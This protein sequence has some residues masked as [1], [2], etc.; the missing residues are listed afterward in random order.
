MV[1]VN[2]ENDFKQN[3][4]FSGGNSIYKFEDCI[5][6]IDIKSPP[7]VLSLNFKNCTFNEL[8]DFSETEQGDVEFKDCH[9]NKKADFS[10]S[11]FDKKVD[12][13]DCVF[14]DEIIFNESTF[15]GKVRFYSS[16]FIGK[17]NFNNT[18][19]QDLADFWNTEFYKPTIFFKTDFIGTTVFSSAEFNENV[20]FTYSLIGKVIIFRGTIFKKG[21][22]ISLAIFDGDISIFDIEIENF[23]SVEDLER[24]QDDIYEEYVSS[25]AIIT[26]KNKRET[27]RILKNQSTSQG[28]N[29]SSLK[30][31]SLEM[32]SYQDSLKRKL[33]KRNNFFKKAEDFSVLGLNFISNNHGKSWSR[34]VLFTVLAGVFFLYLSLLAT[35]NYSF[36]YPNLSC[37]DLKTNFG[38]YFVLLTPTHKND[39]LNNEN[40][41]ELFYMVDFISRIFIAYGIYQTV[42]A[43]RKFKSK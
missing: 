16:K 30:F 8:V 27:F 2:N 24:I 28:N 38:Y 37:N 14:N 13:L 10:N 22:D 11:N 1:V 19:F 26:D 33:Y 40:P 9:F 4:K 6:N 32:K 17:S 18:T 23:E 25:F 43:F 39:F 20:L 31:S 12:F 15:K 3:N 36:G 35:E 5:F 21:L 7:D 42:Q 34:G 29:I 41:T